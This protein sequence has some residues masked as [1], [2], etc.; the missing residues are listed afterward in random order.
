MS[1]QLC[2]DDLACAAAW[3]MDSWIAMGG[4][5]YRWL[6]VVSPDCGGTVA[7][8]LP[9]THSAARHVAARIKVH[10]SRI[11]RQSQGL[12]PSIRNAKVEV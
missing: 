1:A 6:R 3:D 7:R 9:A 8:L 11:G 2:G 4:G 10:D 12:D 5:P